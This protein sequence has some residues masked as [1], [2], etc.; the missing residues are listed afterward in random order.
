M[1]VLIVLFVLFL[2]YLFYNFYYKR[3]AY[4]PGPIPLPLIG[5]IIPL[6]LSKRFEFKFIEWAEQF[7]MYL[8]TFLSYFLYALGP[9]YT[10]WMGETPIVSINDPKLAYQVFIKDGENYVNRGF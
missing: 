8:K 9:V 6:G 3:L 10:Y 2:A 7:G 4:P 1:N 5:N